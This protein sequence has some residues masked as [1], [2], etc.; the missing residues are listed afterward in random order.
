MGLSLN[1]LF[2]SRGAVGWHRLDIVGSDHP[3]LEYDGEVN[4]QTLKVSMLAGLVALLGIA[5]TSVGAPPQSSVTGDYLEMRTCDIYTG[6]CFANAEVGLVG[7]QAVMAW[8]IDQGEL[9]GVD[10]TG[11]KVVL[12]V[13]ASDTLGFGGG[14]VVNPDPIRSVVLVDQRAD[15]SQRAALVKFATQRAGRVAG[16][17]V[18]VESA[19]IEMKVDHIDMIG[20]LKAG[21]S[22]DLLTRKLGNH[23]CVCTNEVVFYP[24]LSNVDNFAPAYTVRGKYSGRG[25]GVQWS[26]PSTRSSF[27]AT[28]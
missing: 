21:K 2:P 24:P 28:F 5:S 7:K 9:D 1:F 22:I 8:S 15:D 23:D 27:L 19:P 6:P 20:S 14:M 4:M 18:R 3:F 17:L 26:N 13:A 11:L 12:A 10:L 16:D 25:L